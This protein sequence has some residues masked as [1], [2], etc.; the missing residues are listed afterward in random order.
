VLL[1]GLG[2]TFTHPITLFFACVISGGL[3]LFS[4]IVAKTRLQV[5]LQL[6]AIF[7]I[8]LL[9][10]ALIRFSDIPSRTGMP[11]NGEQA[12][13]TFQ[14][15]TYVNVVSKVFYGLNPGVLKF[16]DLIPEDAAFQLFRWTPVFLAAAAGIIALLNYRKGPLYWYV[17]TCV[18][19]VFF[20]AVPYTG[21]IIG[22]FV[23]ARVVARAS[24]GC[25]E[26][27]WQGDVWLMDLGRFNCSNV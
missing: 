5:I 11:F 23:S 14:P 4:W 3:T 8:S 7:V 25:F 15:D 6:V 17:L 22:Q 12:S 26:T 10:Y 13:E 18:L 1:I 9:P 24:F 16:I 20:A 21:W 2:L 19:L 27:G